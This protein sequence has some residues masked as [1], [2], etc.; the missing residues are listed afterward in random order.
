MPITLRRTLLGHA[1]LVVALVPLASCFPLLG[2]KSEMPPPPAPRGT[3][4]SL[5]PMPPS[6]VAVSFAIPIAWIRD[7]VDAL[8]SRENVG[9]LARSIRSAGTKLS[10]IAG[11][12]EHQIAGTDGS[13][14]AGTDGSHVARTDGGRI[15]GTAGGEVA[16]TDGSQARPAAYRRATELRATAN[17]LVL[18]SEFA[19]RMKARRLLAN[20]RSREGACASFEANRDRSDSVLVRGRLSIVM[21]LAPTADWA[22]QPTSRLDDVSIDDACAIRAIG[23]DAAAL[24][25]RLVESRL[26]NALP[27]VDA[28]LHRLLAFD[29]VVSPLWSRAQQAIDLGREI[30]VVLAPRRALVSPVALKNDSLVGA[31]G[32]EGNPSIWV[33]VASP[34]VTPLPLPTL[35]VGPVD[36]QSVIRTAIVVADSVVRKAIAD[37]LVGMKLKRRFG[38]FTFSTRVTDVDFYG[39]GDSAVVMVRL[40]G[41]VRGDFYLVGKPVYDPTTRYFSLEGVSLTA[42]SNSALTRAAFARGR[43]DL[44]RA[45]ER[46]AR[47]P[48]GPRLDSLRARINEVADRDYPTMHL[49]ATV[50]EF[51]PVGIV[52][53]DEGFATL[54]DMRGVARITGKAP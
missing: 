46:S 45:V 20:A 3:A 36:S 53:L 42:E 29:Q 54:V 44:Q 37:T 22:F 33:G 10:Q 34:P 39:A 38:P 48:L 24:V 14:S 30:K 47:V 25:R 35:E 41:K 18:R 50:Q 28:T 6:T 7:S 2:S 27:R 16:G 21:S 43:D 8:L 49:R 13:Q 52:R 1:I 12:N 40:A 9:E 11:T 5:P 26:A 51:A 32:L 17:E 19:V 15:V 4:R 31:L 23:D